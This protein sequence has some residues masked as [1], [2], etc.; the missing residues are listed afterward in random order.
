VTDKNWRNKMVGVI[1]TEQIKEIREAFGDEI[2]E[3]AKGWTGTFLSFLVSE[4]V[5]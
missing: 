1:T 3:K 4:G 2:A 5:L